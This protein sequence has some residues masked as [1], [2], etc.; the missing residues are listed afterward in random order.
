MSHAFFE[1]FSSI[2][3]H[4]EVVC[5][6]RATPPRNPLFRRPS[7]NPVLSASP[8]YDII[9]YCLLKT[10]TI[11][12]ARSCRAVSTTSPFVPF[13]EHGH[14]DLESCRSYQFLR[15][16][17]F[18]LLIQIIVQ[19]L[20]GGAVNACSRPP[21]DSPCGTYMFDRCASWCRDVKSPP[22]LQKY[23][24]CSS[25][26]DVSTTCCSTCSTF[27]SAGPSPRG[28][29]ISK[30]LRD[31]SAHGNVSV[32]FFVRLLGVGTCSRACGRLDRYSR[33]SPAAMSKSPSSPR[34]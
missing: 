14:Q 25:S 16:H 18:T 8:I 15:E 28:R 7:C 23:H 29:G 9:F 26:E 27:P 5:V 2:E 30:S 10:W 32:P 22:M 20:L 33:A 19:R 21:R 6:L 34:T 4:L 12:R 1:F 11:L 24:P 17:I 13:R 31:P 3:D